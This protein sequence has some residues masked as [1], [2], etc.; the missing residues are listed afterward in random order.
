MNSPEGR[1][2]LHIHTS[3]G[4]SLVETGEIFDTADILNVDVIAITDHDNL[5]SGARA[6]EKA[7]R[8]NRR[9]QVIPGVEITSSLI[10][11]HI[12]ALFP[13]DTPEFGEKNM[14]MGVE[15]TVDWIYEN[16]G[17]LI[18]P[19]PRTSPYFLLHPEQIVIFDGIELLNPVNGATGRNNRVDR[20]FLKYLDG[21]VAPLGSGDI[22][23]HEDPGW[24][25]QTLFPGTT[26]E[27]L[28]EA[29]RKKQT[30]PVVIDLPEK[31]IPLSDIV[32]QRIY[33]SLI[34]DPRA[35]GR[36]KALARK[37]LE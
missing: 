9:V 10:F 11:D 32:Y 26:T 28:L 31:D 5:V 19:H 7:A 21:K 33:K 15:K 24:K 30:T 14:F 12:I 29:I 27:E 20:I 1:A 3:C 25:F 4:D 35:T 2:E 22:H 13:G 23:F 16:A 18:L 17:L 37:I 8:E 36:L 34:Y 6:R